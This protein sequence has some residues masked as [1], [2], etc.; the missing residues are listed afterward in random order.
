MVAHEKVYFFE[1]KPGFREKTVDKS[2]KINKE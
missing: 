2:K 1:S